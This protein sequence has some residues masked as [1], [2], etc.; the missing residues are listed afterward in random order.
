MCFSYDDRSKMP[1]NKDDLVQGVGGDMRFG[2]ALSGGAT[3]GAAHVGA[4][5]AMAEAGMYPSW[6]SGT[7]AGS[8]VAA[9]YACGHSVADM[10]QIALSLDKS[11]YD[12]DYPGIIGGIL[13][14]IVT[15][16]TKWDGLIRGK[17]LELL[18]KKL[19]DGKLMTE[20]N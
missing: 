1:V 3:R 12:T 8:M 6:I 19:T 16:D 17:K 2:L 15:G 5:K 11:I 9:L 4:M 18:M 13:Q 7:S 20:S 10:E 14:W